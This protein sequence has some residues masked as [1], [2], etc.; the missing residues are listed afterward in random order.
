MWVVMTVAMML[1]SLVPMLTRYRQTVARTNE[2][3]LGRLTGLVGAGYFF[4]WTVYGMAAFPLGAALAA[5]EMQEP[6]LARAMPFTVGVAVLMAGALQLTA[7]KA[8]H[9]A[10]CREAPG[11]A[12][13]PLPDDASTAWRHGLSIGLHCSYSCAAP[14]LILLVIGVMD[15]RVM[16]AVTAAITAERL[17]PAGDR[18]ARVTGAVVVA[19]GFVLTARAVW[20]G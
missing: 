2:T 3:H 7:W 4:V 20:L 9:L 13:T 5:L 14:M 11:L 10:C 6:A 19:A 16:A 1:P 12:Q 17:A 15:L 8:R 18:I